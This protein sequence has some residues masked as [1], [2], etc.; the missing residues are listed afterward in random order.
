MLL[1]IVSKNGNLLL[2]IPVRGD[3]TIDEDEVK[4]LQDLAAWMAVNETS[5][6]CTRPWKI[7]GEGPSAVE[8]PQAGHFGGATD[9]RRK[10]YTSADFRFTTKDGA[11]YAVAMAWPADGKLT[12]RTLA[13]GAPGIRGKVTGVRL[14]GV[15]EALAFYRS[16][17][18]LV[19]T[20][21]PGKPCEHAFALKI[22]GLDLSASEP[23]IPAIENAECITADDNGSFMLEAS[24]A[25]LHG[26]RFR[27]GKHG[28]SV[29]S[30]G[31]WDDFS[32]YLSWPILIEKPGNYDLTARVS[33]ARTENQFVI[34]AGDLKLVGKAPKTDSWETFV[35]VKL[36]S[37][38][39]KQT[40]KVIITVRPTGDASR[41][42]AINLASVA[43]Q[44][45]KDRPTNNLRSHHAPRD[46]F[47][48]AEREDYKS[49]PE[50]IF[51]P[52]L[53]SLCG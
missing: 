36:G 25:D 27:V 41:W 38:E 28:G 34:E 5:I 45:A 47:P 35:R 7:F 19:V 2:N 16:P 17:E 3:G 8:R 14:L 42:K 21:P 15:K 26:K 13:S 20:L 32:E 44:P 6:F 51:R 1:D 31:P 37:L 9:T 10:P 29:T 22:T 53:S 40:G 11:L 50:V 23:V 4:V 30:V 24:Q 12:V 52:A 39:L 18:G 33:S 49:N 48:H 46:V 43:L